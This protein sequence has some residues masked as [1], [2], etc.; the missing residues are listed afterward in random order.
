MFILGI[1][2]Y[3]KTYF[4]LQKKRFV[5]VPQNL[6][7]KISLFSSV[8]ERWSCKPAVVSS[9]LTGGSGFFLLNK[10]FF[11]FFFLGSTNELQPNVG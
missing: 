7:R 3:T 10:N 2:H 6:S 1:Q 4:F 5:R 9:I 8:V 11:L